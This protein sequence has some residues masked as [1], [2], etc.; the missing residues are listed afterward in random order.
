MSSHHF[1]KEQQEPAIFFHDIDGIL[2]EEIE[3]LLEWSPLV[4]SS[5]QCYEKLMSWS[6]KIDCLIVEGKT[7]ELLQ[8]DAQNV[9]KDNDVSDLIA[10]LD[11]LQERNHYAVN[12]ITCAPVQVV[13]S[14]LEKNDLYLQSLS[15][16]IYDGARLFHHILKGSYKKWFPS[17]TIV[18]ILGNE[19]E[20]KVIGK[21]SKDDETGSLRIEVLEDELIQIVSS[22]SFWIAEN[23]KNE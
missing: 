13:L 19:S 8:I 1:V 17:G 2:L 11:L 16:S 23:V 12:V 15:I 4:I 6:I 5:S 14:S 22:G 10:A 20:V 18:E 7:E 3:G 21:A 9:I